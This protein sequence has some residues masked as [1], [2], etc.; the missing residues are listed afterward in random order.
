MYTRPSRPENNCGRVS[1]Y[2]LHCTS[3]L[4]AG[5]RGAGCG[6]RSRRLAESQSSNPYGA[7][8]EEEEVKKEIEAVVS[9]TWV[10]E[11]HDG[12]DEFLL[13]LFILAIVGMMLPCK[14]LF[15]GRRT[16]GHDLL[17]CQVQERGD[18]EEAAS[19]GWG[20][21]APLGRLHGRSLRLPRRQD[22]ICLHACIC[23]MCRARDTYQAAGI[24]QYWMVIGIFFLARIVGS[25]CEGGIQVLIV[26][27]I[28]ER[29]DSP[30]NANRESPSTFSRIFW[31]TLSSLVRPLI[32]GA[33]LQSYRRQLRVKLGGS[34]A[35]GAERHRGPPHDR[36]LH[37]LRRRTG[38][39]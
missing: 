29:D 33:A 13:P 3:G 6:H 22:A 37:A 36:V 5:G 9:G 20:S 27:R 39:A 26:E 30:Y 23:T 1:A 35:G 25:V 24:T 28:S 11:S 18:R 32:V 15:H 12:D 38:S 16:P 21:A 19:A 7:E 34:E 2:D 17:R 10:V 4:G 8:A 31:G 14:C